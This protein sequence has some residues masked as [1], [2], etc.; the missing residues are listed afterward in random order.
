MRLPAG[1]RRLRAVISQQFEELPAQHGTSPG[2]DRE[3]G[4]HEHDLPRTAT[5]DDDAHPQRPLALVLERLP[6][7]PLLVLFGEAANTAGAGLADLHRQVARPV[8]PLPWLA[9]RAGG[10]PGPEHVVAADEGMQG[11]QHPLAGDVARQVHAEPDVEVVVR[12]GQ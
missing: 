4:E 3:M 1:E 11:A 9:V 5:G 12:R 10:K 7:E 6:P 8:G 2:V